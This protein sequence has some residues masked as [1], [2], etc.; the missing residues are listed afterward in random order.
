[1]KT[2]VGAL[3]FVLFASQAFGQQATKT[4]DGKIKIWTGAGLLASGLFMIPVRP[5][6]NTDGP[7]GVPLLGFGLAAAGGSLIYWGVRDRQKARQPNTTIGVMLRRT[8]GIQVR[9]SW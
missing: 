5:A 4:H 8:A 9:R 2:M 7:Y 3:C 6:V 1:M